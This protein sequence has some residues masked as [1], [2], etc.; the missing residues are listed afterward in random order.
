[1]SDAKEPASLSVP[2]YEDFLSQIQDMAGIC[3]IAKV[4]GAP[5]RCIALH[6]IASID[7]GV[8]LHLPHSLKK[9]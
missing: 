1:M 4:R 3:D 7:S 9:K 2:D 5:L 8:Y 6:C